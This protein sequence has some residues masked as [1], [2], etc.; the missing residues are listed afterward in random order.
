MRA[1]KEPRR[2]AHLA[3]AHPGE[4]EAL[5]Q[6][7]RHGEQARRG[8]E[9]LLRRG[10]V[11]RQVLLRPQAPATTSLTTTAARA[12]RRAPGAAPRLRVLH[13]PQLCARGGRAGSARTWMDLRALMVSVSWVGRR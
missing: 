4:R 7:E 5:V 13:A 3:L 9:L 10:F 12:A 2:R 1:S 6:H 8:A 11:R